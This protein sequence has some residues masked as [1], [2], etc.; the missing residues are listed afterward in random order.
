MQKKIYIVIFSD[1]FDD[2]ALYRAFEDKE[3]AEKVKE[4]YRKRFKN[5]DG[6]EFFQKVNDWLFNIW[7]TC[8]Q[9][10]FKRPE[11]TEEVRKML[12]FK[13]KEE[14]FQKNF[15]E[16]NLENYSADYMFFYGGFTMCYISEIDF[17]INT[18][19]GNPGENRQMFPDMVY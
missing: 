13:E 6:S 14:E 19:K 7:K 3:E 9:K 10:Y 2:W 16:Y 12:S 5:N 11:T 8:D 15:P 17:I 18:K 1:G 4:K